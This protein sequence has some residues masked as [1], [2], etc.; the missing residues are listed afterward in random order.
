MRE[1]VVP[2]AAQRDE[3]S[4]EMI[5]AWVAEHSLH[6]ALNIGHFS[7]QG[8]RETLGWGILLADAIRHIG[9]A[10]QEKDG[11]P[12]AETVAAVLDSLTSELAEPTSP[13]SGTFDEAPS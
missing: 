2:L 13:A 9:N 5:R 6:C 1:L 12:S 7:A 11:V 8:H 4:V 10:I 3:K